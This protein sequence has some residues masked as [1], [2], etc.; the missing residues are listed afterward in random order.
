[1]QSS[2]VCDSSFFFVMKIVLDSPHVLSDMTVTV[3]YRITLP[4]ATKTREEKT[5]QKKRKA[6]SLIAALSFR[7]KKI[8][9][10]GKFLRK[11]TFFYVLKL[12]QN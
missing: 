4:L 8:F 5:E 2:C 1:M 12:A 3:K 6:P 11:R 7:P 10:S 9:G